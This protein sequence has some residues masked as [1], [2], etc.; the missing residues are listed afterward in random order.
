MI[1]YLS[2]LSDSSGRSLFKYVALELFQVAYLLLLEQELEPGTCVYT[3]SL[4]CVCVCVC[5]VV[6]TQ[7]YLLLALNGYAS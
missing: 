6:S 5:F 4:K 3:H 1:C 7:I 2:Y